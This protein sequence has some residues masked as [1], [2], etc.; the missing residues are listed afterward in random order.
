MFRT[1][2]CRSNSVQAAY[3]ISPYILRGGGGGG[4][5]G[6]GVGVAVGD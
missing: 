5:G 1:S 2:N 6:G 4:G 3:S